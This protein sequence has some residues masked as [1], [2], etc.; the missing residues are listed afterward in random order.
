VLVAW[1]F[2]MTLCDLLDEILV[3]FAS[4]HLRVELRASPLWQ[5]AAVASL[6]IGGALGL[7]VCDRLLRVR[8][9]RWVLAASALATA[10]CYVPWL[11]APT[12]L[13]STLLMLPV[14]LCSAP[15]YPLAA[16]QAYARHPE[17][18]GAV[19]A[20]GHLFTPLGLA[21]PFVIGVV[22]DAAGTGIALSL[23]VVQPLGLVLLVAATRARAATR[24]T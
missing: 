21:L 19:L 3:V 18:S 11:L 23:L 4:L 22:A 17:A 20:A 10:A 2:G 12:P 9:E 5:S 6:V 15:L 24:R 16:A 14:G 8:S 13:V 1:L 7:V